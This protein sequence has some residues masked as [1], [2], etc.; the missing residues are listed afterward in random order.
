MSKADG[1]LRLMS[2]PLALVIGWFYYPY[3]LDGPSLCIWNR[4]FDIECPGCGLIRALCYI[5]HG[6]GVDAVSF[7]PL[8]LPVLAILSYIFLAQLKNN[9]TKGDPTWPS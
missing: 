3:C 1:I 8:I 6:R 5:S 9:L 4:I 2:L 7:N